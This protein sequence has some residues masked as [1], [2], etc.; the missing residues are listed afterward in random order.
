[1][2]W[3]FEN[4]MWTLSRAVAVVLC[5]TLWPM[6]SVK[7][8]GTAQAPI[9][10]SGEN[11]I[12]VSESS[13]IEVRLPRSLPFD[14]VGAAIKTGGEGSALALVSTSGPMRVLLAIRGSS[15]AEG[16]CTESPMAFVAN[17]FGGSELPKGDY[18]L[19][20]F[21][22]APAEIR[23]KFKGVQGTRL[24]HPRSVPKDAKFVALKM[25]PID[26]RPLGTFS[27]G[28]FQAP[29]LT[30]GF[31]AM[32][33][34]WQADSYAAAAFGGCYYQ[35]RFGVPDPVAFAPGCPTGGTHPIV[36]VGEPPASEGAR[37][38]ISLFDFVPEGV[39][40]WYQVAGAPSLG[41]AM[42]LTIR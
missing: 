12:V 8:S 15:C 34:W 9:L 2:T 5:L 40:G 28:T 24:I 38:L 29:Q 18:R 14:R 4:P 37:Y 3:I 39:G 23:L 25:H 1:M 20:A 7:G 33:M 31:T 30:G 41:G 26:G 6:G 10:L 32:F 17:G 27:A 42:V 11:R 13:E 19:L 36:H 16:D 22:D 35:E 21:T